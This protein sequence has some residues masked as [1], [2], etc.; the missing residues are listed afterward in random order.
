LIY[1]NDYY[2]FRCEI[3]AHCKMSPILLLFLALL[4][5]ID[6]RYAA[7]LRRISGRR[8]SNETVN[9]APGVPNWRH[10]HSRCPLAGAPP[11]R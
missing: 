11:I 8:F 5:L 4:P 9:Y 6:R 7:F 2:I 10:S 3:A 1:S